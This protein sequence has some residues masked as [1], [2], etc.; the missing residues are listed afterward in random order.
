[1]KYTNSQIKETCAIAWESNF[2]I[3]PKNKDIKI[4]DKKEDRTYILFS[5]GYHLY[6]F[7][8]YI[9]HDNSLWCGNGTVKKVD[10]YYKFIYEDGSFG[11]GK[12]GVVVYKEQVVSCEKWNPIKGQ[13]ENVEIENG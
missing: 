9:F 12:F 10:D 1:M 8:S 4:I 6:E 2:G 5:V 11:F 7:H 3:R 13:F